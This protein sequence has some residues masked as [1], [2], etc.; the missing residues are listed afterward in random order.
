MRLARSADT[1]LTC[2]GA[3]ALALIGAGLADVDDERLAAPP[4]DLAL[5]PRLDADERVRRHRAWRAAVA[6]ARV[7]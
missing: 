1:E 5:A 7:R 2:R 3:A 4:T 6:L